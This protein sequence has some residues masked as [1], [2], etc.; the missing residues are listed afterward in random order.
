LSVLFSASS[1]ASIQIA[2]NLQPSMQAMLQRSATFR[3]Q[4]RH[5]IGWNLREMPH[6]GGHGVWHTG[7]DAIET[8]R[9]ARAGR[10]VLEEVRQRIRRTDKL[11]E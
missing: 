6:R 8:V 11:V 5:L 2:A 7:A 9:A 10:A 3:S 4:Y 1:V